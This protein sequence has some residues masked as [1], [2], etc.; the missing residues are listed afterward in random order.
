MVQ[1]PRRRP[2]QPRDM[3]ARDRRQRQG[4]GDEALPDLPQRNGQ[5]HAGEGGD[6]DRGHQRQVRVMGQR[7]GQLKT[8][9][10]SRGVPGASMSREAA[11]H[12]QR[13]S[14]PVNASGMS[15]AACQGRDVSKAVREDH[16]ADRGGQCGRSHLPDDGDQD[17]GD[18]RGLHCNHEPE[19]ERG[20][21]RAEDRLI[22][23]AV[24]AGPVDR[25]MAAVADLK[26]CPRIREDQW[27][28]IVDCGQQQRC[29]NGSEHA[30][31]LDRSPTGGLAAHA[32]PRRSVPAHQRPAGGDGGPP[33]PAEFRKQAHDQ[34]GEDGDAVEREK[35][36]GDEKAA[37]RAAEQAHGENG[38]KHSEIVAHAIR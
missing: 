6:A 37:E 1:R 28:A 5:G 38:C 34:R 3:G 32:V 16:P 35:R 7:Q 8:K 26:I 22:E 33:P 31:R 4:Q 2:I 24:K 23:Q 21:A 20:L 30:G 36:E 25:P 19:A 15:W 11:S 9:S 17:D 13:I 29:K 10:Q 14:A 27:E 18:D 12:T